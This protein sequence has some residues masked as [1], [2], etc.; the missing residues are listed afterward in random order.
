MRG[1]FGAT[2]AT[3]VIVGR[4]SDR[5]RVRFVDG[6]GKPVMPAVAVVLDGERPM[7]RIDRGERDTVTCELDLSFEAEQRAAQELLGKA[8]EATDRGRPGEAIRAYDEILA[9]Y[10]FEEGM[11]QKALEGMERVLGAGRDRVKALT[12]RVDDARFFRTARSDDALLKELEEE[13]A[14][15]AGTE[16][17]AAFKAQLETLTEERKKTASEKNDAEARIAYQRAQDY[18]ESKHARREVALAFLEMV[19]SRYPAT[20]WAE[21]ARA[22][23]EQLSVP[24][25]QPSSSVERDK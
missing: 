11:E 1:A 6:E 25:T 7:L 14:R 4:Q 15:Y 16:L 23:M 18:A 22:L 20:E 13:T 10:S 3:G 24:S 12:A 8:S 9:R 21:R 2:P 5:V 19:V 17:E